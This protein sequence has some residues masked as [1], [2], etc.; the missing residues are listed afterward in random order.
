[1]KTLNIE[2]FYGVSIPEENIQ[3]MFGL[4]FCDTAVSDVYEKVKARLITQMPSL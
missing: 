4:K 2:F 1:V 3:C